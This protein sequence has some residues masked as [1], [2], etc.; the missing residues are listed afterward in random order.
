[1]IAAEIQANN[2]KVKELADEQGWKVAQNVAT[3]VGGLVFFPLWF[4]MD[5][6]GAA[7]KD[8][9]ALQARQ[10]FLTNLAAERC[11]PQPAPKPRARKRHLS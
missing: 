10:Q 5:F 7:N 1:M 6:K 4:G 9:A 2:V 3:G 11:K 8:A